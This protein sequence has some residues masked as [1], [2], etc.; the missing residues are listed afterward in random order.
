VLVL[1]NVPRIRVQC[2]LI[3]IRVKIDF[4]IVAV[5]SVFGEGVTLSVVAEV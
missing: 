2:I 3:E 5:D 4:E 1:V